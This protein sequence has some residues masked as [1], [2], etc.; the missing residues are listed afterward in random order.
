MTTLAPAFSLVLAIGLLASAAS[1]AE[2]I[3]IK[4]SGTTLRAMLYRPAGNGP[5][6]AVV[7][8]HGCS[9]LW[10]KSGRITPRFDD[11][12]QRLAKDGFAA[13]FPDSFG[14]R[15]Q[16]SQCSIAKRSVLSSR[17]RVDDANAALRWLQKQPWV[18]SDRVSVIGWSN[19]ATT[20]LY[21]IREKASQPKSGF[22]AAI[23]LYPGCKTLLRSGW[24]SSVP[25]LL[26]LGAAD[27]WTPAKPCQEMAT[28]T[29]GRKPEVVTYQGAYHD[30]DRANFPLRQ[31]KDAAFSGNG[32]GV[33]HLG[34]NDQARAD[35]L[36]RVPKWLSQ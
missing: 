35:V 33:V 5:V 4:E 12:G 26:L 24:K 16:G 8:L 27:D 20:T 7:A 14:S 30:F 22:R 11:W 2:R 13:V 6:P 17:E 19:G 29:D 1:A 18:K 9:G 10:E 28:A 15:N 23:A 3:E 34:G 31:R 25:T 36:G 21:A 32:S